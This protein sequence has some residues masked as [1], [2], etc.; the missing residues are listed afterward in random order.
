MSHTGLGLAGTASKRN[1]C[2]EQGCR[3]WNTS[4]VWDGVTRLEVV[5]HGRILSTLR[6]SVSDTKHHTSGTSSG[7]P[8]FR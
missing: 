6:T 1:K 8:A 4:N 5:A 7:V 2:L 3:V